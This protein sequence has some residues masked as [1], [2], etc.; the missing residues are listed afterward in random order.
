M[1]HWSLALVVSAALLLFAGVSGSGFQHGVDT[2]ADECVGIYAD[3]LP[4]D[5][6]VP[7]VRQEGPDLILYVRHLDWTGEIRCALYRDGS[8]DEVETLNRKSGVLWTEP[9]MPSNP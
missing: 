8:L 7:H 4:P 3:E 1:Q 6:R 5:V 2:L 9:P